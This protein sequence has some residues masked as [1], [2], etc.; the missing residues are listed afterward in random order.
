[1]LINAWLARNNQ[2][3]TTPVPDT[4]GNSGGTGEISGETCK[5][6]RITQNDI[7]LG[8]VRTDST[9][10][11][12]TWT[13]FPPRP[14]AINYIVRLRSI[15]VQT[16]QTNIISVTIIPHTKLDYNQGISLNYSTGQV[17]EV[18]NVV[19]NDYSKNIAF[20][21]V[22]L[23]PSNIYSSI[24]SSQITVLVDY[25]YIPRGV[26]PAPGTNAIPWDH[27]QNIL[28]NFLN[29]QSGMLL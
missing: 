16:S 21:F 13:V 10:G 7:S 4:S 19:A 17:N 27:V 23:S 22:I 12:Q 14:D 3:S 24:D 29:Q 26:N 20:V 8:F 1:M 15:L 11:M 18:I 5:Q 2:S 6:A 9:T 28:N 25:C